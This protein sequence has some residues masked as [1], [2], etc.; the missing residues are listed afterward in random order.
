MFDDL[1]A[2]HIHEIAKREGFVEYKFETKAGS[3]DGDNFLG[4]M[5]AITLRGTKIGQITIEELHLL[6]KT[7]QAIGK[8]RLFRREIY[9]YSKLLPAF[10]EFQRDHGLS[11]TD[12]FLLFPKVYA[13][14]A[15]E[16]NGTY[17][18]IMQD[19]RA[20]HF[21]MWPRE[22]TLPLDHQLFILRELGKLHGISFAMKAQRPQQFD[23]FKCLRDESFEDDL[24]LK[25]GTFIKM[26]I[27]RA[28]N[29]LN[30]VRH[31]RMMERFQCTYPK[32]VHE[33]ILGEMSDEFAVIT[34]SDCWCNN[35]LFQY[36]ANDVSGF[37][38]RYKENT[39]FI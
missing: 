13:C 30:D 34:H 26:E 38:R 11:D 35:F 37:S 8:N 3:N 22:D 27:E 6:C 23:Q 15:N 1:I 24:R 17:I 25:A 14:E 32:M 28:V 19:L 12:R 21:K 39:G 18:L 29:A 16:T 33:Y 10:V 36:D 2:Y 4:I 9:V 31:K 20:E 7:P 5:T